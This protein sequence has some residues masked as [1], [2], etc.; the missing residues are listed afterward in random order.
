MLYAVCIMYKKIIDITLLY[1]WLSYIDETPTLYNNVFG[2]SKQPTFWAK[3]YAK[4]IIADTTLF[5]FTSL[6]TFILYTIFGILYAKPVRFLNDN[7]NH[8]YIVQ[9]VT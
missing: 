3:F 9:I 7:G 6:Y 8:L 5:A 2:I 4:H 1:C